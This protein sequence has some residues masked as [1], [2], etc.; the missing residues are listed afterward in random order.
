MVRAPALNSQRINGFIDRVE[1]RLS[2]LPEPLQGSITGDT[3]LIGRTMDEIAWGQAVSL[4]GAILIIYVILLVYFR[5]FRVA[6]LALI[7]NTL[8]V[9][10]YFGILGLTGVTLNI[11]TSLIA[12][13]VLG[14]AVDDTIHLLVRFKEIAREM[15]DEGEAVLAALRSVIRPV[16]S[17]TAALCAGFLVLAVSGLR[18][19]VEF[20]VLATVMLAVAWLVDVTFTPALCARLGLAESKARQNTAAES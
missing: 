13:I 20:A 19:Q 8:P 11:F 7:P 15:D 4:T 10:I 14:I 17:T 3:V 9:T 16:T 5:S 6:F 1:A 2:A 12:C 18:H